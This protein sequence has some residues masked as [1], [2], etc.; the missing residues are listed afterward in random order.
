[1]QRNKL[2]HRFLGISTAAALRS[3]T[4]CFI[5]RAM[6]K[7]GV[8]SLENAT[9]NMR[10]E[11]LRPL[12]WTGAFRKILV[13]A[14]ALALL[15]VG[16]VAKAEEPTLAGEWRGSAETAMGMVTFDLVIGSDSFYSL[17]DATGSV[18]TWQTGHY[19]FTAADAVSFVV[20]DWAPKTQ[21][22]YRI[23]Q[24]PRGL[25]QGYWEPQLLAKP[26]GGT[27]R[28]RFTSSDSFTMEDVNSAEV[29]AFY[30]LQ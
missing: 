23:C 29:V 25:E 22:V 6:D 30:R 26:P 10:P 20:E 3:A 16:L 4:S 21:L 27:Y 9:T 19:H 2:Y 7:F 11:N 1:M 15:T 12:E 18:K 14:S 8:K 24:S 28:I 17:Q 5:V 13:S